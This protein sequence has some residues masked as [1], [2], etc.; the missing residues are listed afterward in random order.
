MLA[1]KRIRYSHPMKPADRTFTYEEAAAEKNET[2]RVTK[3]MEA[4]SFIVVV[5]QRRLANKET[6]CSGSNIQCFVC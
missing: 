5:E 3:E 4:T 2:T 6:L 1:C